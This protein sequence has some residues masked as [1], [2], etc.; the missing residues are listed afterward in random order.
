MENSIICSLNGEGLNRS[1]VFLGSVL[2]T[3]K[4]DFL[5]L[6]ELWLLD[7][8]LYRLGSISTEYMYTSISGVDSR[9]QILQ[10]RPRGGVAICTRSPLL[11]M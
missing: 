10:G 2:K 4:C 5:C 3:Y 1:S 6:Q 8:T 11:N 7:E 9:K